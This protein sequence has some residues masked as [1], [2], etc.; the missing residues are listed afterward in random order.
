MINDQL[1]QSRVTV[2]AADLEKYYKDHQEQF[3][4]PDR[5]KV[6]HILIKTP[7]VL[8]G[9][10]P[11]EKAVA[12]A[13]KKAEDILKQVKSGGNFAEL[14]KKN[15]DDPGSKAAGGELGWI[16]KGQTV[17]EFEKA[18]FSLDKGQTSDLVQT[19]YGFHIIQTEEKDVAHQKTLA[20]VK[21][22]K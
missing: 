19:T 4:V 2:T 10:K 15:S 17:P 1:A 8:P 5:V 14:A 13:R 20:E 18:A 12:E 21:A 7:S 11:D 3:K 22:V 6:R 9:A 16:V